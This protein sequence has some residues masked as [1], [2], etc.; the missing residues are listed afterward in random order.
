MI[1]PNKKES[2]PIKPSDV[3]LRAFELMA[4]KQFQDAEKLL[5][6]NMSRS[7]DDT[8]IA[9]YHSTLGVLF[10]MQGEYKTAWKHYE[11]AEKLLPNDPALKIISARLL[12]EQFAEYSQ[13]IKK[14]KKVLEVIPNNPVFVHQAHIT[15]G[16]AY[17]KKGDKKRAIE[18]LSSSVVD[19]FRNFVT[20]KNIDFEL[21]EMLLRKKWGVEECRDFL[22][23]ARDFASFTREGQFIELF[24]KMLSAFALEYP[25]KNK[26]SDNFEEETTNLK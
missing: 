8:A 26:I 5:S 17:C 13:A 16:L 1:D 24:E 19:D 10:K 20:A 12:V 23:K 14:A 7:D 22:V 25:P 3:C 4:A 9:L 6:S 11:R 18:M 21:V 15:M 2:L